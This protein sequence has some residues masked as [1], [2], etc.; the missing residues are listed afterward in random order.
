M[1]N[2][3]SVDWPGASRH[4]GQHSRR[5]ES[6]SSTCVPWHQ[7]AV[8]SGVRRQRTGPA[9]ASIVLQDDPHPGPQRPDFRRDRRFCRAPLRTAVLFD[10]VRGPPGRCRRGA[11]SS[12]TMAKDAGAAGRKDRRRPG[13]STRD[14][15]KRCSM[16]L[17]SAAGIILRA[18][19]RRQDGNGPGIVWSLGGACQGRRGSFRRSGADPAEK[20]SGVRAECAQ[21]GWRT[22]RTERDARLRAGRRALP[23]ACGTLRRPFRRLAWSSVCAA[24]SLAACR[25]ADGRAEMPSNNQLDN[26][27]HNVDFDFD[28]DFGVGATHQSTARRHSA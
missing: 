7:D 10:G 13:A 25:Y 1:S 14:R 21:S 4:R 28:F 20:C 5:V 8:A 12:R 6:T 19:G 15:T 18:Q 24:S 27:S 3:V 26:M 23:R 2:S 17:Q 11:R 22:C 9:L 16:L